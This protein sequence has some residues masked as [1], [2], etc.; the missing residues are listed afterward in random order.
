VIQ[1]GAEVT[2]AAQATETSAVVQNTVR[3]T[4]QD[5]SSQQTPASAGLPAASHFTP[6]S[7]PTFPQPN[8]TV[9]L[10][11]KDV[12]EDAVPEVVATANVPQPSSSAQLLS[13][14]SS[15]E[16]GTS[17]QLTSPGGGTA[18]HAVSPAATKDLDSNQDTHL[19]PD[20]ADADFR[21]SWVCALLL[22]LLITG[23]K[24]L[25]RIQICCVQIHTAGAFLTTAANT[26][27][28]NDWSH[29]LL[30]I[31]LHW[32]MQLPHTGFLQ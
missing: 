8:A 5:G 31:Y 32:Y 10:P 7:S 14:P 1:S 28:L 18:Q 27:S 22:W 15:P 26:T 2:S 17:S 23:L 24:M 29:Q 20:E 12:L 11:A 3:P 25:A 13:P 30:G 9:A 16:S 21:V 19:A 4:C 6:S